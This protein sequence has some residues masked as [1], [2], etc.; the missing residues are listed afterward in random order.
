M[1]H[2]ERGQGMRREYGWKMEWA[3][4]RG[5]GV[6]EEKKGETGIKR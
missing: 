6:K 1:G 5:G 3:T 4:R 2:E